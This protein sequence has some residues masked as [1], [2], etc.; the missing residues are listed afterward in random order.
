MPTP[1]HYVTV[2]SEG[3]Q[4]FVPRYKSTASNESSVFRTKSDPYAVGAISSGKGDLG[5]KSYGVYQFP[6]NKAVSST[7][8]DFVNWTNNPYSEQL[9]KNPL[10]SAAFDAVWKSLATTDN[11][12]FGMAQEKFAIEVAWAPLLK[13]FAKAA[14]VELSNRSDK[15]L[16]IAVGTVNQYGTVSQKMAKYVADNGGNSL[17]DNQIG[18]LIQNFKLANIDTHFKSSSA[19]VRKGVKSR[20]MRERRAFE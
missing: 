13:R 3:D 11:K 2:L 7:L 20:I 18:L 9:K 12:A 6:S 15:L 5:G 17:S 8:I 19:S 1:T 14:G 10:A 16:D 4:F